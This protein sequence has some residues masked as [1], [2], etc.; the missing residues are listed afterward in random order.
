MVKVLIIETDEDIRYLYRVAIALQKINVFTAKD[1][2]EGLKTIDKENPNLIILDLTIPSSDIQKVIDKIKKR[3]TDHIL[4]LIIM[5]DF[6]ESLREQALVIGACDY[7]VK[8]ESSI[9][10]I[11]TK[12]RKL[13][14]PV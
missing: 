10:E 4:P 11:I 5:G 6:R 13:L 1:A 8:S 9:G 12:V 14:N 7:L 3:A 2:K